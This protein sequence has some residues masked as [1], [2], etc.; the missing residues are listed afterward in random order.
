M[1]VWKA[2]DSSKC[3]KIKAFLGISLF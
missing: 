3:A 1:H 2:F